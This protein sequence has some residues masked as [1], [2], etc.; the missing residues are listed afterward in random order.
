MRNYLLEEQLVCCSACIIE[1]SYGP[2][3][4]IAID[5]Q[6]ILSCLSSRRSTTDQG[7]RGLPIGLATINPATVKKVGR[8]SPAGL[9]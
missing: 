3:A 1:A 2:D 8:Q 6:T 5:G 7:C 4:S 9:N